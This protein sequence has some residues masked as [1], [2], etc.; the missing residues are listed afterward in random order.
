[1]E[2]I[3]EDIK[4]VRNGIC[5][6]V[7]LETGGK[8]RGRLERALRQYVFPNRRAQAFSDLTSSPTSS[9]SVDVL[10]LWHDE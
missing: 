7:V 9:R 6:S 5:A 1:M 10:I 2:K 8:Q 4:H 3:C